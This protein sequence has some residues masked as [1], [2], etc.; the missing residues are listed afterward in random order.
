MFSF[1]FS[2]SFIF[3]FTV[4]TVRFADV[5]YGEKQLRVLN[6]LFR[7]LL[8][9]NRLLLKIFLLKIVFRNF[10]LGSCFPPRSA[11]FML[12]TSQKIT[13]RSDE[14]FKNLAT[15]CKCSY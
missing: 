6:F 4:T 2:F 10:C 13:D 14:I 7:K 9:E 5:T 8:R 1:I 11:D 15:N 3:R 12:S